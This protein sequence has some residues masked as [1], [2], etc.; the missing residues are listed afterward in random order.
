M[1]SVEL[2][3]S[4]IELMA[5]ADGVIVPEEHAFIDKWYYEMRPLMTQ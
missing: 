5:N 2:I 3:D 1:S 4:V